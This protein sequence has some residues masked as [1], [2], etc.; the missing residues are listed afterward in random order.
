[1]KLMEAQRKAAETPIQLPNIQPPKLLRPP[2]PAQA[3]GDEVAAKTEE[4]K[5]KA[6]RRTNTARNTI[7]AG[8][9]GGQQLGGQKT[10]LG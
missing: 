4:E 9:T 1:M 2:P 8:E 3:F 7:F 6:A 10:L 5:R